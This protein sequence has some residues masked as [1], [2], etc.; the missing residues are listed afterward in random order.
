[1]PPFNGVDLCIIGVMGL[2]GLVGLLRG[3]VREVFSLFTWGL[4]IWVGLHYGNSVAD[5]LV[6]MIPM[7]SARAAAA[8]AILFLGTLMLVGMVGFVL[9]RLIQSTGLSGI[10]RLAGLLFGI[11]RGVLV[12]TVLVFLA[13]ET[14]FPKDPWWQKSQLIPVFQSLAVWLAKEIPPG[15]ANR[16][17]SQINTH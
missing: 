2:S 5:Y 4:A 7:P 16:L 12:V 17:G 10:D 6:E 14:P 9:S 8:F 11:A 1:M 13:R 3:F 15:Y